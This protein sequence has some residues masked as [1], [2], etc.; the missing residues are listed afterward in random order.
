MSTTYDRLHNAYFPG[1]YADILMDVLAITPGNFLGVKDA[2]HHFR[3][4]NDDQVT[5]VL[6]HIVDRME[7]EAAEEI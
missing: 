5:A 4:L 3:I 7:T 6:E 2:L 1:E